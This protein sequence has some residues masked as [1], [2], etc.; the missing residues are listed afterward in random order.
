MTSTMPTPSP[1]STPPIGPAHL[2]SSHGQLL[3]GVYGTGVVDPQLPAPRFRLKEWH[4]TSVVA[5][6]WFLAF[7]VVQ[8]GYV[9]NLFAYWLDRSDPE[10]IW[11]CEQLSPLGRAL[12]FGPSSLSGQTLWQDKGQRIAITSSR[13]TDGR[14]HWHI[15]LDLQLQRQGEKPRQLK[16]ELEVQGGEALALI[17]RLNSGNAAYTHKECGQVCTGT[18]A[19]GAARHTVNALAS[20]DWTRSHAQRITRWKWAS[21]ALQ[22]PDGRNV[23]LNLSAEVYD[24]AAGHS[25]ENAL[26]LQGRRFP[27]RGVEF[28][29]PEQPD[30]QPW[31]I[32]SLS[33]DEVDLE[34]RPL[35]ARRQNLRLGVVTSKFIQPYGLFTGAIRPQGHSA[36]RLT[37]AFG[38][39]EN[40]YAKW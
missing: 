9:A 37:D 3:E 18:L 14:G 31:R 36:I 32:Q 25:R 24:D 22:L 4:Y 7:A 1:S 15:D 19:F 12:Q 13:G 34:F 38:V 16:A 11:Q 2:F 5:P 30:V 17:H 23:G 20:I 40:H 8:V 29:V 6:D 27:L 33:G 26:W 28:T 21:A 35:G 10:R 39:V